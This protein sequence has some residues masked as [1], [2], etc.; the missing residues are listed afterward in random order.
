MTWLEPLK[1]FALGVFLTWFMLR[2]LYI[3]RKP[4]TFEIR[5]V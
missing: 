2:K 4:K 3:Y 5:D 1:P